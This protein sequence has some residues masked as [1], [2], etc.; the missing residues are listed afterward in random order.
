MD[1]FNQASGA[2]W[3]GTIVINGTHHPASVSWSLSPPWRGKVE[4]QRLAV[5]ESAA[6]S[7]PTVFDW[8][9]SIPLG[10][11]LALIVDAIAGETSRP[12]SIFGIGAFL[13][14]QRACCAIVSE[15]SPDPSDPDPDHLILTV[16]SPG[17]PVGQ[18]FGRTDEISL[19]DWLAKLTAFCRAQSSASRQDLAGVTTWPSEFGHGRGEH[20]TADATGRL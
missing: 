9:L 15:F 19:G 7:K 5:G 4:I 10:D 17:Q 16:R 6:A 3:V 8:P 2:R 11:V 20:T 13:P 12:E 14:T 1:E 18:P